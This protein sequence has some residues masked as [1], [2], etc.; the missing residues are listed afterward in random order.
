MADPTAPERPAE[1]CTACASNP[2]GCKSD[3]QVALE[4]LDGLLAASGPLSAEDLNA[5]EDWADNV[6]LDTMRHW[7]LRGGRHA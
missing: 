2:C 7:R 4:T 6:I 3:V 1:E 5:I